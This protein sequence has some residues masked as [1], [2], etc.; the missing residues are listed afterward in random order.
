[1]INPPQQVRTMAEDDKASE[2]E[3]WLKIR[4]Q[5]LLRDHFRCQE[6]GY[7]KHLEVHHIVPKCKGGSDEPENLITYC[8]RCHA[9]KHGFKH[10]ENKR[11]RH[12]NRNRRK[13]K[14]RWYN[15]HRDQC[16]TPEFELGPVENKHPMV[17]DN[18]PEA[19]ARRRKNY[20]KWLRNELNQPDA[21]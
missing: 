11:R 9:K 17:A 14:R 7:Y 13:H 21:S 8:Q 3:K 20:E 15:K 6:C 2:R 16:R 10:R 4:S 18:S 5:I 1:M 12:T 19:A